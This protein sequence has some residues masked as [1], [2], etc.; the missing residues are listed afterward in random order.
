MIDAYDISVVATQLEDGVSEEP[1]EKLDGTIEI[2]TAKRN[3]SKGDVVEVLVKGVYL[4]SVNAL[5][6]ALP[7]NQQDY[8]FVGVEPLNLKD[9]LE[10]TN[11]LFI[12]KLK[13]KRAVKFDLKA[14]DGVLVDKNLNT[15]KF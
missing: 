2:S 11:D 12:L 6:F 8:E 7:Y 15:R 10:G 1:I 3:Y 14:I 4:R 13:A 9:A 5:S